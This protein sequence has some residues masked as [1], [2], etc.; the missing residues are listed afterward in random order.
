[1]L[2][3]ITYKFHSELGYLIYFIFCDSDISYKKTLAFVSDFYKY[4]PEEAY[5]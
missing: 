4:G 2:G 3:I 5:F 1:M